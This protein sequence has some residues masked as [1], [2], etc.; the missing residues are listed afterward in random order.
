MGAY[1][2][3]SNQR[4][5]ITLDTQQALETVTRVSEQN[6]GLAAQ[7]W[8]AERMDT[9]VAFAQSRGMVPTHQP[10]R[11]SLHTA[12]AIETVR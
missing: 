8:E 11:V 6:A 2:K 3:V 12:V 4:T 7:S 9:L 5:A 10:D 1:V